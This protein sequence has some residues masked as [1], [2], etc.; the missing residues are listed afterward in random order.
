M[1]LNNDSGSM[2]FV[3]FCLTFLHFVNKL[4]PNLI[5]FKANF[6]IFSPLMKMTPILLKM[7]SKL[8]QLKKQAIFYFLYQKTSNIALYLA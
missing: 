5:K 2:G 6:R 8:L 4:K 7:K 1:L 3:Y